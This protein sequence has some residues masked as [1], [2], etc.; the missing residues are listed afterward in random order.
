MC[1]RYA[2]VLVGD[3]TLQR[4]FSLEEVLEDPP[5]R[6]NAAPTQTLPVIIGDGSNSLA[7][8]KWG[9]IPFWAKD[10]SIG[11]R[12]INARAETVAEKPAFK[13]SLRS[14]RCLV[15]ASGFFEWKREGTAKTPHFIHVKDEPLFAFAGLYDRWRDP[16]G[17]DVMSYSILTTEPNDLMATIHNRMPVVLDRDAE[18]L[19]L[20]PDITEPERLLPLLRPYP[21][22]AMDAYPVSRMVNSPSNDAPTLLERV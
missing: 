2:I 15:P 7:M 11:S 13:R 3:G 16:D 19:W 21:A 14:Q 18:E 10:A 6:Y 8:M 17:N 4:R 5:A 1:G 22:R 12:M 20:D 9:L